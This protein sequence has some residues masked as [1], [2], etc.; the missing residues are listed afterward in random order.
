[1]KPSG[2]A[3][4]SRRADNHVLHDMHEVPTWVK[5]VALR[6]DGSRSPGG[7]PVLHPLAGNAEAAGRTPFCGL[8]QFLLNKW[9]FD[10]LYN[11]IFVRPAMWLGRM[12]WKKGDGTVIDGYGPNGSPR[13]CRTCHDLG[14]E[15][16]DRI[17]LPLCICDADRCGG[18]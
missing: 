15:T 9:Y 4:S 8:Y 14:R 12:L 3:R 11:F 5:V 6:H 1:M 13:A 2:R 17:S 7:L 10:E 16:A 18:A